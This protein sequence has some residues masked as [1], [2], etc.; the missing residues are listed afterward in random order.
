[1]FRPMC[2]RWPFWPSR[3]Q[4]DKVGT[5]LRWLG[6]RWPRCI[7][8]VV[9]GA[10]DRQLEVR[11]RSFGAMYVVRPVSYEEWLAILDSGLKRR[12]LPP[13]GPPAEVNDPTTMAR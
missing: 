9:S 13:A 12:Q 10:A 7:S 8:V 6:R 1:M 5:A 4:S 2:R 11:V 3:W